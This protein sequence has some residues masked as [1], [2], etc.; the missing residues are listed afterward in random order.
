VAPAPGN[1][2]VVT[3][4]DAR[5]RLD[6]YATAARANTCTV[7]GPVPATDAA[8]LVARVAHEQAAAGTVALAVADP[9]LRGLG[10]DIAHALQPL[11]RD[12]C[13]PHDD[14]WST[15]LRTAPVGVTGAHVGVAEQ[16]V[17][18]LACGPAAPRGTSLLPPVHVCVVWAD[19]IVDTFAGAIERVASERLPSALTWVGGPSR[20]GDLEMV[21][22]LGVHGP[23]A[24]AVVLVEPT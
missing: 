3:V 16:G 15:V 22:T 18:A 24:V 17:V 21:T 9:A 4:D 1:R 20:T 23:K 5:A 13:R 2:F 10:D 19:S 6:A 14:A 8:A 7:H 12:V 11:G